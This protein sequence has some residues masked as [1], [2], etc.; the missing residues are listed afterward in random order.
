MLDSGERVPVVAATVSTAAFNNV[1]SASWMPE[2]EIAKRPPR[3]IE[4]SLT[5]SSMP[6]A[7]GPSSAASETLTAPRERWLALRNAAGTTTSET[8]G[9]AAMPTA[10]ADWP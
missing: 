1:C 10:I 6:S 5:A 3:R 7:A 8:N 2:T 4:R 9:A